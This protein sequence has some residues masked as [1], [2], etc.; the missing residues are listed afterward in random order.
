MAKYKINMEVEIS[1]ESLKYLYNKN[2][3]DSEYPTDKEIEN[4]IKK[5]I[6]SNTPFNVI[7]IISE[8]VL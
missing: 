7:T 5:D 4:R 1:K 6:E 3:F 2:I 8:K